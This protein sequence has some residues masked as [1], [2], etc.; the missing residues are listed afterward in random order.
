[1]SQ[2]EDLARL[3]K[4]RGTTRGQVTRSLRKVKEAL[5]DSSADTRKLRQLEM[6]L[7]VHKEEL[8]SL[9]NE[10]LEKM[11]DLDEKEEACNEEANEAIDI[12]EKAVY[13]VICLEDVL[14]E[15]HCNQTE[16]LTNWTWILKN[17]SS[18]L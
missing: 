12:M 9:D 4:R 5:D 2:V 14:K 3:K 13:Y 8:K 11:Y 17:S 7:N 10:I 18:H 1:M 15:D 16:G 6:R